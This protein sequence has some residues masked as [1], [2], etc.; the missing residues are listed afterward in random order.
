[1][2]P[3]QAINF[4]LS[5]S[6]KHV[7]RRWAD[8]VAGEMLLAFARQQHRI[9]SDTLMRVAMMEAARH[10][11]GRTVPRWS[12][13]PRDHA[14]PVQP[15]DRSFDDRDEAAWLLLFVSPARAAALVR[16]YWHGESGAALDVAC[17][18]A[19]KAIRQ[20]I[21]MPEQSQVNPRS[22]LSRPQRRRFIRPKELTRGL[23]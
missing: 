3:D 22:V 18:L 23:D 14:Q 9:T 4:A 5:W 7:G 15:P 6:R 20:G 1:M 10:F 2:I 12:R 13:C 11:L 21:G 17:C 19:R 8:D 16:R